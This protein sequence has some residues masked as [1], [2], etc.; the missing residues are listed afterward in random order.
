MFWFEKSGVPGIVRTGSMKE[1][2]IRLKEFR[3]G[4]NFRRH[5]EQY[6]K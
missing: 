5:F 1:A 4:R 2:G 3:V 6:L